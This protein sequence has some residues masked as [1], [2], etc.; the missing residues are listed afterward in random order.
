MAPTPRNFPDPTALVAAW[1]QLGQPDALALA[2]MRGGTNNTML[3]LT[4]AAHGAASYVLR[5][6]APHH[7]ERRARLEHATLEGLERQGL[8]FAVPTPIPTA[9]GAPW[10][11]LLVAGAP[12]MATLT[13]LIP[14]QPP[15]RRDLARAE[16]SG[17]AIGALD[18]ALA[19]I[20]LPDWEAA[21]SWRSAGA[22]DGITPLV[23]DPPAAFATLPISAEAR[24]R[25]RDGYAALMER[26]PALYAA[27]PQQLCHE[28]MATTNLLMDGERVTGILDFEFLARDIRAT[29]LAVAL[30]WWPAD[31]LES[32]AEWPV[33][34]ALARGYAR[35]L[36]LT[37]AEI[38]AIPT[39][40]VMRGYTSLIHRLGRALQG[41]SP[42]AHVVARAEAAL[43]WQ[44]WL[45]ASGDRLVD[46]VAAA[47][48]GA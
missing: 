37:A 4:S 10:A 34:A 3:R 39:L 13:R 11:R 9:D 21:L 14:G 22:L 1:P 45:R 25:L 8:P 19:A 23:P 30:V 36:R 18:V 28:D 7:D 17:E 43:V 40:Y 6:A 27:L 48:A 26:L 15:E 24:G 41:L 33:I 20:E 16:R 44:D 35:S 31:M 12:A 42:V 29:D 5:L 38:A 47:M 2:P 32:G 46:V